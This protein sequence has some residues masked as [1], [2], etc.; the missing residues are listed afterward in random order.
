MRAAPLLV[1]LIALLA[2]CASSVKS[3]VASA[4]PEVPAGSGTVHV[5]VEAGA[6]VPGWSSVAAAKLDGA[7]LPLVLEPRR[8]GSGGLRRRLLAW[9]ALPAGGYA[10]IVLTRP[11]RGAAAE[12][13]RVPISFATS[14]RAG[15]VVAL[16][17]ASGN[18]VEGKLVPKSALGATA[19]AAC[20]SGGLVAMF[21][22]RSGQVFGAVPIGR[23]PSSIALDLARRRAYVSL[24]GDDA[25]ASID[26]DEGIVLDRR[27]LRTGDDPVD[28]AILPDGGT[29]LVAARGSSSL[30]FVDTQSLA[31]TDRLTV[32]NG[33]VSVVVDHR[34]LRAF[35]ASRAAN[36]VTAI[37]LAGRAIARSVAVDAEPVRLQ[38]DAAQASLWVLYDVA[39]YLDGIDVRSLETTTRLNLGAGGTAFRIEPRSGRLLVARRDGGG[40][41][42]YDPFSRLPV[43]FFPSHGRVDYLATDGESNQLFAALPGEAGIAAFSLVGRKPAFSADF[44]CVPAYLAIAGDR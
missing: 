36:A 34:A 12:E 35:V 27:N 10:A 38:L 24:A 39:P 33:P 18:T 42:V 23:G 14:E 2:A 13:L 19:L 6:E 29:L 4:R 9:G 1:P 25:I 17:T 28:L 20:P 21:D 40:I 26:L 15:A 30:I 3:P 43:D 32:P 37:D 16:S 8:Q 7:L 22:K 11:V 5:Y 31:E 41:D 44:G